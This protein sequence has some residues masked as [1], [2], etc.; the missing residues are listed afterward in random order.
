MELPKYARLENERRFL[1]RKA[2]DL[3]GQASRLIED[4]YLEGRLRLRRITQ[5]AGGVEHKLC[6]KYGGVDPV[7][8]P[9]TNLYLTAEEYAVFAALPGRRLR[10]RRYGVDGVSLDVFEGALAG[11]MLCEAEDQTR[12]AVLARTFPV[13]VDREVTDDPAFTGGALSKLD[14]AGLHGLLEA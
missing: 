7:S 2:P 12:E 5:P 11:L 14:A 8:G 6:K 10:K 9:V 3:G 4:L 13:W 1:V